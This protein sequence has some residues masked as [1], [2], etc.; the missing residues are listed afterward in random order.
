MK[1]NLAKN[2]WTIEEIGWKLYPAGD[3]NN[4]DG[5]SKNF[6]LLV[7]KYRVNQPYINAWYRVTKNKIKVEV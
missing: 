3:I 7:E 5:Q 2:N 1:R 6:L 4:W